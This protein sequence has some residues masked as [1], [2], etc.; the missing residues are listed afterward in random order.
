VKR[1]QYRQGDVLLVPIDAL[2]AELTPVPREKGR[3]ILAHG[4]VTGHAHAIVDDRAE[5]FGT[6]NAEGGLISIVEAGELYLLVHG[7]KPVELV[8]DEHSTIAVEPGAYKR[9]RQREYAPEA[10]RLV[11]D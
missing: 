4:E 6:P 5:L 8:H 2:P 1:V 3:V 10:T 7:D 11:A 9:I